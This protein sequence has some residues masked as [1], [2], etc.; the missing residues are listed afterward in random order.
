MTDDETR[1]REEVMG[2]NVGIRAI[3]RRSTLIIIAGI[4]VILV[5]YVYSLTMGSYPVSFQE[6]FHQMI[7]IITTGGNPEEMSGKVI[8][9]LRMP[10]SLLVIM[11]G[12]GL[13]VAGAVMQALIHN[14]LVDPYVTGVSSGASFAVILISLTGVVATSLASV[15]IVPVAAVIGAVLAFILT[16]TVAESAG[17]KAMSYVLGGTIIGMG[18]SAG[19]TLVLSTNAE[20]MHRITDWMFGSFANT[21]WEEA[22]LCTVCIS[23]ILIIIMIYAR[24]LNMMLLGEDQ[25]RYLGLDARR[26]KRNMLI[27]VAVL[28][29]F[30]VAFCGV[31]G[32]VGL[33]VPHL[34]RMVIGGDNRVLLPTS[35][36]VGSVVLLVADVFCKS[37]TVGELPIGAII[38]VIG[39]PFFIYLMVKE[40]K[41][42]AL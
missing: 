4:I 38:S 29:A 2:K 27:L 42:Y 37:F 28:T 13:A 25:A 17:G 19:T 11:V 12:A 1:L 32:F 26:F 23:I 8:F 3:R 18:L 39:V 24:K 40:G 5:M 20:D 14:P 31:I 22:I 33:I 30:C 34:C 35:I 15:W 36:V 41:R 10:R 7:E 9:H 21:S 6:S 16:M